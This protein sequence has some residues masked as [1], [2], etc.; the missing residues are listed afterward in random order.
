MNIKNIVVIPARSGSKGVKNKNKRIIHGKPLVCYTIETALNVKGIDH[1]FLTTND[2][3]IAGLVYEDDR[4]ELDLRPDNLSQDN[5][6]IESVI[7]YLIT[8]Y[9]IYNCNIVLLQPTSP[10]RSA[11]DVENCLALLEEDSNCSV[12]SVVQV[13]DAHPARM[14]QEC[15]NLL[16]PLIP[17]QAS[18]RRQ[19]LP[20]RYL[21]NG[22]IYVF[23]VRS[24][25]FNI[26][27]D[28]I[29]PYHMSDVESVNIDT[30]L[31]LKLLEVVL[32][33]LDN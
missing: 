14:Y 33:D 21:R 5:T 20:A 32:N 30:E 29:I 4:I 3:D 7:E 2:T 31:D 11:K 28:M 25:K 23:K 19:D 8:K 6:T 24:G 13:E 27:S 22:S 26:I 17:S 1:I 18:W 12:V 9:S 10:M 16:Q 15:N